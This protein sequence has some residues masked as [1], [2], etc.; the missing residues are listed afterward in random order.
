MHRCQVAAWLLLPLDP[1]FSLSRSRVSHGQ[2]NAPKDAG[3]RVVKQGTQG[4]DALTHDGA[5]PAQPRRGHER[6]QG[7]DFI[8][9][10]LD[11]GEPEEE[12]DHRKDDKRSHP[13]VLLHRPNAYS[14]IGWVGR[15]LGAGDSSLHAPPSGAPNGVPVVETGVP[16]GDSVAETR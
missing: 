5:R 12:E 9:V 13:R 4:E 3:L 11:S 2:Q 7:Y 6:V 10:H 1:I 14:V 8:I 16:A 15:R